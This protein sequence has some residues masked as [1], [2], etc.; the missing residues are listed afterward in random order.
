MS[1]SKHLVVGKQTI[2]RVVAGM[3]W[4]YDVA[5][6]IPWSF[7]LVGR[8]S[9]QLWLDVEQL[10]HSVTDLEVIVVEPMPLTFEEWSEV[11]GI[12]FEEGRLA[13]GTCQCIPMYSSPCP[14]ITDAHLVV[15]ASFYGYGEGLCTL[16]CGDDATVPVGLFLIVVV[17]FNEDA[18]VVSQLLIPL[19][20]AEEGGGE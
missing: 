18:V 7:L 11:V 16:G 1:C 19:Y 12:I 6:V 5:V 9:V 15:V 13:V 8:C 17:M 2:L 4:T 10:A 14:M 20:G 3:F